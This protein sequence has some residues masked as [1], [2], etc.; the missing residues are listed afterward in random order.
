[1]K[2]ITLFF[3]C[4]FS[5]AA[6]AAAQQRQSEPAQLGTVAGV[7]MAC[8]AYR[9]LYLYEEITSRLLSNTA[10]NERIEKEMYKEYAIAKTNSF[11]EQADR[12]KVPCS[13]ATAAFSKMPIFR[14]ELYAD[15]SLKSPEGRYILPRGQKK[16]N[17]SVER[18]Y[19]AAAPAVPRPALPVVPAPA[20]SAAPVQSGGFTRSAF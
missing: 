10:A 18:I 17:P 20:P 9:Q 13:E 11:R 7:A 2:K 8:G 5:F 3:V 16:F 19:P 14:F 15:G 4:F 6:P 12:R 1:M